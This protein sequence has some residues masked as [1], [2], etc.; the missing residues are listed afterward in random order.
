LKPLAFWSW[1]KRL[2]GEPKPEPTKTGSKRFE[3]TLLEENRRRYPN[4]PRDRLPRSFIN[5]PG[6]RKAQVN[7][8]KAGYD[9]DAKPEEG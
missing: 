4:A 2:F 6:V 1:L 9:R 5:H 3:R 7:L 8:G